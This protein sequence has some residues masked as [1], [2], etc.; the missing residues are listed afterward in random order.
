[1]LY[2]I[3]SCSKQQVTDEAHPL[4]IQEIEDIMRLSHDLADQKLRDF[5]LQD[6]NSY[7]M[8]RKA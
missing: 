7:E 6:A 4:S 2:E 1:M 5:M 3:L 8:K